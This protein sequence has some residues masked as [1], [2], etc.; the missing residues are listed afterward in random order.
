[1]SENP[2]PVV[3]PLE[4]VLA[5]KKRRAEIAEREMHEKQNILL[6]EREQL[7][8]IK[9]Q[10][11]QVKQHHIDKLNQLRSILDREAR[12][13]AL[14]RARNYV[15]LVAERLRTEE[16]RV[17]KQQHQVDTAEAAFE[18]ARQVWLQRRKEVEKIEKHRKEWLQIAWKEFRKEEAKYIEEVGTL[19]YMSVRA[20]SKGEGSPDEIVLF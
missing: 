17:Q 8:Y 4:Q 12:T 10:R 20:R 3:Y 1:M 7:L 13:N 11:D 5:V 9:K 15:D 2:T 19:I 18:M 14:Q 6:Q 16:E